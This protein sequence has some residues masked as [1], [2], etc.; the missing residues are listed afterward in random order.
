MRLVL[1]LLVGGCNNPLKDSA[2]PRPCEARQ[3][4]YADQDGDGIGTDQTPYVGCDAPEGY[5]AV[6]GDCNDKDAAV[7]ENCGDS[8]G[9]SSG[10]SGADSGA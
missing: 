8:G 3:V 2:V 7:G 10:D 6:A 5:V 1:L 9:D 4:F